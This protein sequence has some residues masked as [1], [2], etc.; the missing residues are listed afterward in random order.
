MK[1]LVFLLF[2][3]CAAIATAQNFRYDG[4][5]FSRGGLPSPGASIAVCRQ[6]AI[7][8]ASEVTNTV[9]ITSSL[10]PSLGSTVTISGVVPNGYNG[11]YVVL[12][13]SPTTFTYTNPTAGL[14]AGS[15]FGA[16]VVTSSQPCA[17]LANLCSSAEDVG[18]TSP[19]PVISDG[20]G[21]FFL[22]MIPGLYTFQ[23]Y[24]SGMTPRIQSDQLVGPSG[25]SILGTNNAWTGTNAWGL[26]ST[27][28]GTVTANS[29]SIF[30]A[31]ATFNSTITSTGT[32]IFS[33]A[34]TWT[35]TGGSPFILTSVV[36]NV[37]AQ[38]NASGGGFT[39]TASLQS[40]T[41]NLRN[42][43]FHFN[44]ADNMTDPN[45][46]W[47]F[48]ATFS[49][50]CPMQV[51]GLGNG[52]TLTNNGDVTI[53]QLAST[54]GV[55]TNSSLRA[56]VSNARAEVQF[57]LDGGTTTSASAWEFVNVPGGSTIPFSVNMGANTNSLRVNLDSSTQFGGVTFASLPASGNGS[58]IY[59]TNCGNVFDDGAI[60]G[61]K[62][63]GAGSGALARR[64]NGHWD[65]N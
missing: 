6:I 9:T 22:Y 13:S 7:T 23:Y 52:I 24:G 51:N 53:A 3:L 60:A 63:V 10:N 27:F 61:A 33:G 12:F 41:S 54:G 16:A 35:V 65:C 20:L 56:V 32:N 2:L 17:P 15:A 31:G 44:I 64:Q 59:C 26:A 50:T 46:G 21:N 29:T 40:V 39:T 49:G 48:C 62:C 14:G 58:V 8:A 36:G 11:S 47:Y 30:N 19:N 5:V 34:N 1:K 42:G 4:I 57:R 45:A 28:N 38:L 18:C 37:A 25:F 43:E 55:T